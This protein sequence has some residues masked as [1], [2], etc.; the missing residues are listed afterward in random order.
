MMFTLNTCSPRKNEMISRPEV[1]LSVCVS[2]ILSSLDK[3]SGK[4]QAQQRFSA[5]CP[6]NPG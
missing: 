3:W 2:F 1:L 6:D 4:F 5:P